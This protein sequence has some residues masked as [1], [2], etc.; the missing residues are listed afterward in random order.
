MNLNLLK[1][2]LQFTYQQIKSTESHQ[3]QDVN[4]KRNLTACQLFFFLFIHL[5]LWTLTLHKYLDLDTNIH[6]LPYT[7][8]KCKLEVLMFL[9]EEDRTS[10]SINK[11][12][13]FNINSEEFTE[14]ML[15]WY[16][17]GTIKHL[18]SWLSFWFHTNDNIK[19]LFTLIWNYLKT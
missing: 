1:I 8:P 17:I 9:E 12:Y 11:L 15:N 14:K 2:V 13:W 5:Y 6:S 4:I 16:S 18:E 3:R 19:L 7:K 10:F